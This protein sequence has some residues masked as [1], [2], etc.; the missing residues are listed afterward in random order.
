MEYWRFKRQC[1]CADEVHYGGYIAD[2]IVLNKSNFIQE[3]EVKTGKSDLCT[4]ELCKLKHESWKAFYPDYFS[5]AVPTELV[6]DALKVIEKLNPKYGLIEIQDNKWNPVCLRK[7]C[8]L[9]H[10][11]ENNVEEWKN[12]I[13]MR[14]NSALIGYM[15]IAHIKEEDNAIS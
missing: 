2:V 9:L 7:S 6:E 12:R 11:P 3:F 5:F 4:A 15:K 13:I 14:N 10:K 1:L 8:K